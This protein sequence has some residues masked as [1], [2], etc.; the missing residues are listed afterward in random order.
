MTITLISELSTSSLLRRATGLPEAGTPS[1]GFH[2]S[3]LSEF[4]LAE[5]SG[6]FQMLLQLQFAGDG[7]LQPELFQFGIDHAELPLT[8]EAFRVL[9]EEHVRRAALWHESSRSHE[10]TGKRIR[11]DTRGT[12]RKPK[13]SPDIHAVEAILRETLHNVVLCVGSIGSARK[14]GVHEV[15]HGRVLSRGGLPLSLIPIGER[16]RGGA[17]G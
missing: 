12:G 13:D 14:D 11:R 5:L 1:Y 2:S 6:G 7:L 8:L 4:F 3:L 9:P 17:A 10:G 16:G 15:Q